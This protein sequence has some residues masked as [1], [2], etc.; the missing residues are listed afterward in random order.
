MRALPALVVVCLVAPAASA[1]EAPAET[2]PSAR[3]MAGQRAFADGDYDTALEDFIAAYTL[4]PH[5]DVLINIATTYERLYKPKK[6]RESYEKFLHDA[7]GEGP[8]A[9]LAKNRLRVLRALPGSILVDANKPN[10][11][12]DLS[13]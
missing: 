10:A 13:G 9:T 6:A 3:F 12:V 1:D 5:P 8:L 4:K 11:R 7:P 2:D